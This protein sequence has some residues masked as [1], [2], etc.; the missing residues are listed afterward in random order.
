MEVSSLSYRNYTKQNLSQGLLSLSRAFNHI[1]WPFGV[2]GVCSVVMEM[3]LLTCNYSRHSCFL[4]YIK[5]R[6]FILNLVKVISNVSRFAK[7]DSFSMH[8]QMWVGYGFNG[9]RENIGTYSVHYFGHQI[10]TFQECPMFVTKL[11]IQ[12]LCARVMLAASTAA[13][14][15]PLRRAS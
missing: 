6:Q 9:Q 13:M 14:L 5:A 12:S 8:Y 15:E 10:S 2:D 7:S 11:L 4:A 1:V 3:N